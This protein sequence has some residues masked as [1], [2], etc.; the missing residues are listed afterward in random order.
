MVNVPKA[1]ARQRAV[2]GGIK[3]GAKPHQFALEP[4]GKTLL[5]TNTGSGE[6]EAVTWASCREAG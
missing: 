4:G 1:L 6:V 2:L 5:V 3:S